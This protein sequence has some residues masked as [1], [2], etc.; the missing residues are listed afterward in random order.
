MELYPWMLLCNE[1]DLTG[2]HET[3]LHKA[4]DLFLLKLS[5]FLVFKRDPPELVYLTCKLWQPEE[6]DKVIAQGTIKL[7]QPSVEIKPG[8]SELLNPW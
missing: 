2:L 6:C 7:A 1:G 3:V 5:P 4:A 8:S